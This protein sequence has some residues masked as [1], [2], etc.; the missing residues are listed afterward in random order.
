MARQQSAVR[1]TAFGQ[2]DELTRELTKLA[3]VVNARFVADSNKLRELKGSRLR[4]AAPKK[5]S[6]KS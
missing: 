2:L 6:S 4:I 1:R 3:H 5:R